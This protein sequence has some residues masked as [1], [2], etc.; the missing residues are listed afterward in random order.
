MYYKTI[1]LELLRQQTALHEQLR[2]TKTVVH[3][4]DR[5]AAHLKARH[6]FW[7][8]QLGRT[9]TAM[10]RSQLSSSALELAIQEFR[11]DLTPETTGDDT[12]PLTLDE[13]VAFLRRFTPGT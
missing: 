8:T 11:D 13:A 4:V 9:R 6:E 2:E 5:C 12:R 7:T 3:V 1:V 10:H